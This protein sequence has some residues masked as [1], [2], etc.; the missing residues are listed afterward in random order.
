LGSRIPK[1]NGLHEWIEA[2]VSVIPIGSY[3][4]K[5]S[6]H[7]IKGGE[8]LLSFLQG[9]KAHV[10]YRLYVGAEAPTS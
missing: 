8:P 10:F 6:S 9:L 4:Y 1:K 3:D 7:L 5:P 2:P